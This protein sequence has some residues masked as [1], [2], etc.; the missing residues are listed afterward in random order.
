M[1]LRTDVIFILGSLLIATAPTFGILL[2]GRFIVGVDAGF[3]HIAVTE[4]EAPSLLMHL[5]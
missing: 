1:I 5:V 4:R 2:V 3:A